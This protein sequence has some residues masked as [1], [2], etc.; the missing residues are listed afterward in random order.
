MLPLARAALAAG[1]DGLIV[2]AHPDP[3]N[4]FS[5]A[6]QQIDS[7]KFGEFLAEL[8]P[9]MELAAASRAGGQKSEVS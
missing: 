5:D 8:Q 9:W 2:E 4:A 3:V 7:A 6:A 1:A